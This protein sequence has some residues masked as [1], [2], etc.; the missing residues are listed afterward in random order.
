[1]RRQLGRQLTRVGALT[2]RLRLLPLAELSLRLATHL[3]PDRAWFIRLGL[4]HEARK[5][6][7][8]AESS[9]ALAVDPR[10][11][12]TDDRRFLG[13]AHYRRARLSAR[14]KDWETAEAQFAAA[15]RLRP[16][17]AVWHVHRAQ[18][19]EGRH[20]WDGAIDRYREAVRLEPDKPEWVTGLVRA[21]LK[22][23]RV[24]EA[25]EAGTA[26]LRRTPDHV[27]LMRAV[28]EAHEAVGDWHAAAGILRELIALGDGAD[29]PLR[30]QL[31][32]C[33]EHLYRVPF[34][35]GPEGPVAG[36]A[37]SCS[38]APE[39]A[40]AEAVETLRYMS[41]HPSASVPDL[42]RL[43]ILYER[44]GRVDDAAEAYRLAV[45]RLPAVDSW[46]CHKTAYDLAYRLDYV[47]EQLHPTDPPRWQLHRSVVPAGPDR[48]STGAPAGFFDA[49][50]ARDGLQVSGF[51]LPTRSE[52]VELQLDG[53]PL[54]QI[55]VYAPP[56]R[57]TFRF[58]ISKG[59]L[60]DF[61]ERSRLS[62][63]LDGRPLVTVGGAEALEIR[64]AGGTGKI[65]ED[66]RAG[67]ALTKKGHWPLS[68]PQL[69]ERRQRYLDIYERTRDL[70]ERMDRQLFLCYGTLL[71][72]HREGGFIAGDDDFDAS[73]VST[74][75]TP[76]RYRQECY[77]TALSLLDGGLDI[78]FAINGRM[79][80]AGMDKVW[81]DIGP[82]W[83]HRG[84][85]LSFVVHDLAR[86]A[87]EPLQPT[88]FCGRKVYVPRDADAFLAGTY[89]ADWRTPRQDFRY[90]RSREDN[91]LL[92]QMWARPSEVREF[93]RL[94]QRAKERNPE[95]GSFLGVGHPAYPGF[96]WLVSSDGRLLPSGSR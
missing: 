10:S 68:G 48:S 33:L 18:A 95:A 69:T 51:L 84:R 62:V 29:Y 88:T 3:H 44:G 56:W 92:S 96:N 46:W 86:E 76:K 66:L 31:V 41:T 19:R 50:I 58:D 83:L 65:L 70:L 30:S 91:K 49:L 78:A 67:R 61:P 21:Y 55:R 52:F 72:C 9:Y 42:V 79:F 12:S 8:K 57:P 24:P 35:L 77:E 80:K 27:P 82:V 81:I 74:A 23:R 63:L 59:T 32:R 26:G 34:R 2:Q 4:I 43:G 90:Y 85:A 14:G 60:R 38:A 75:A 15:L 93:A 64:I 22:A 71:G 11:R 53:L 94:A 37:G 73:Y 39:E 20:D 1:M 87:I 45:S 89:G 13:I 16:D 28:A 17:I 36:S 47:Q 5:Q 54:K 6:W 7:D 40:L 25:V